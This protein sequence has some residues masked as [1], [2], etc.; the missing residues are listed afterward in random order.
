LNLYEG[1]DCF[2]VELIGADRYDPGD[3]DWACFDVFASDPRFFILPHDVV[4]HD[5]SH[6]RDLVGTWVRQ[7]LTDNHDRFPVLGATQAVT[8]GFVDGNL[9]KA[10]P[11]V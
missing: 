7:Y 11:V 10:W 3:D 8:V 1:E 6:V 4:G 9:T 2:R 5:W